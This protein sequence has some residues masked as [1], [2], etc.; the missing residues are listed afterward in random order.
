[1]EISA[2]CMAQDMQMMKEKM[3]TMMNTM[4]GRVSNN[5]DKLVQRMDS[6]FI[7]Q[8]TSFTLFTKF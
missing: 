7:V 1:M 4:T 8:V 2:M 6:F 3:D 5:L